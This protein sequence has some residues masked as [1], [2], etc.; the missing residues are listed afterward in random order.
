MQEAKGA[1]AM[2]PDMRGAARRGGRVSECARQRTSLSPCSILPLLGGAL[3]LVD[4]LPGVWVFDL[5]G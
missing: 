5:N 4:L 3:C 2:E 1:E